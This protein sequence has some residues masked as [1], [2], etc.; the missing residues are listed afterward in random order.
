MLL[1]GKRL[2]FFFGAGSMKSDGVC[3]LLKLLNNMC[4]F[5]FIFMQ[6]CIHTFVRVF[7][8]F[9]LSFCFCLHFIVK[10][11]FFGM[12]N[13]YE[14]EEKLKRKPVKKESFSMINIFVL[15][16]KLNLRFC[17]LLLSPQ[18]KQ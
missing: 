16:L 12:K 8:Y 15:G 9:L 13:V 14:S 6:K 17:I 2:C 4:S 5:H 11:F 3:F 18:Q 10:N 1:F 7:I